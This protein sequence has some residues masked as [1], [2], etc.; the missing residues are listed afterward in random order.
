V[1]NSRRLIAQLQN[2][3]CLQSNTIPIS[4]SAR[5]R[6]PGAHRGNGRCLSIGHHRQT[7]KSRVKEGCSIGSGAVEI[8]SDPKANTR[9]RMAF[10]LLFVFMIV[11]SVGAY[12]VADLGKLQESIAARESQTALQG[13][14][15]PK[16]IDDALKQHPS[17]KFLQ[18]IA[19]ATK[20]ANE[21]NA[22]IEKL[23]NEVE[24]PA[25]SKATDLGAAS[26]SDLEARRR[27][28]KT[29]EANATTLVP[30]CIDLLK[31]EREKV[32]K[33]ALSLHVGKDTISRFLDN[34][35]RRHA[36]TTAFTSRMLLARAE[37][38]RAYE[39]YVGVLVGESGAYKVANGQ[40]IFPLQRTAERYNV[41]ANA[42]TAAAKRVA[43]LE[44][45]GKTLMQSQLAGW[46]QFVNAE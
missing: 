7:W 2:R 28:L 31:T 26:R 46:E 29:A 24:P 34:I 40:F 14:T 41:A 33:Y 20:A 39:K 37:F 15:D 27:D 42:M 19:M 16:Q 23:S 43:E 30:R 22:V 13:I 8:L 38:Y 10:L 21:T 3:P 17:N 25:I 1:M 6:L 44:E 4:S 5:N 36:E 18:M 32:E 11:F 9:V 35:D 12:F 45:E